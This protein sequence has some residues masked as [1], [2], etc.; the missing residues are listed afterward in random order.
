MAKNFFSEREVR[1]ARSFIKA[2][3]GNASNGYLLLAVIAWQRQMSRRNEAFFKSLSRYDAASAGARLASR[4][5]TRAGLDA[6]HFKGVLQSLRRTGGNA[7]TQA[8][9]FLLNITLSNWDRK[10]YGYR[11]Y[12]K[13]HWES[14]QWNNDGRWETKE[15][16]VPEQQEYNPLEITWM[17]LT[18][19]NI[20]KKYFIDQPAKTI[21]T[22]AKPPKPAPP[23]QP[24]SL[25]HVQPPAD[26]LLPYAAYRFYQSRMHLD[27]IRNILPD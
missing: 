5:A 22:P 17:K 21:T 7:V 25:M 27:D 23:S 16:W 3:K 19:H 9:D 26:Y 18:G 12:E 24:R 2:I 15:R 11:P 6:K 10:H 4:L 1:L 8:K 20:P 13:G 14:Y